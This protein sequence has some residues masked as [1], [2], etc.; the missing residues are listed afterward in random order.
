MVET[1]DPAEMAT[2]LEIA[3]T[4][5]T[6][7]DDAI[8]IARPMPIDREIDDRPEIDARLTALSALDTVPDEAMPCIIRPAANAAP[9]SAD[10]VM[11]AL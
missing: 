7:P 1:E 8:P 11:S 2:L 5:V 3:L 9:T 10:E 4:E 6:A